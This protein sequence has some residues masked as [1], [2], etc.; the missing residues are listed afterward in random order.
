MVYDPT[1]PYES[2][3]VSMALLDGTPIEPDGIYSVSTLD[4][5][6]TG[7]DKYKFT[8]ATN[9]IDTFIPVRQALVGYIQGLPNQTLTFTYVPN[10]IPQWTATDY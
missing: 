3:V 5:L 7:G 6:V 2:K 8:G 1:A 4:F 10:L 9:V